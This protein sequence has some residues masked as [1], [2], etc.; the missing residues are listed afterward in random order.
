MKTIRLRTKCS[1]P[2]CSMTR[3]R[4]EF[5]GNLCVDCHAFLRGNP[6]GVATISQAFK[7]AIR[8]KGGIN[9][10]LSETPPPEDFKGLPERIEPEEPS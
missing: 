5:I 2:G 6:V 10:P 8:R 9:L 7:N 4:R 1:V 3:S